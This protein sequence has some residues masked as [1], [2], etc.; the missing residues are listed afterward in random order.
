MIPFAGERVDVE[1]IPGLGC[2]DFR[3]IEPWWLATLAWPYAR[4]S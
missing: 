3:D 2:M 1:L 4:V